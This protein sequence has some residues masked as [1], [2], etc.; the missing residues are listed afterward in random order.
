MCSSDPDIS[1]FKAWWSEEEPV[2]YLI[3]FFGSFS[4]DSNPYIKLLFDNGYKE[5]YQ[6]KTS[7]TKGYYKYTKES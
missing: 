4:N 5:T 3:N 6:E 2:I 7:E 1:N